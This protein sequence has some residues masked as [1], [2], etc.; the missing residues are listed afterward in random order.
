MPIKTRTYATG[1]YRRRY[2]QPVIRALKAHTCIRQKLVHPKI[3]GLPVYEIQ[4][5]T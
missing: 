5:T 3:V 4:E 1:P 2:G